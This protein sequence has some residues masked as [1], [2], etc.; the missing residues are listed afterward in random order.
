MKRKGIWSVW[1]VK[2]GCRKDLDG[3]KTCR[4]MRGVFRC[5]NIWNQSSIGRAGVSLRGIECCVM[6]L[7]ML[8]ILEAEWVVYV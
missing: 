3:G 8:R 4:M 7:E 5:K 6:L 1:E 2:G